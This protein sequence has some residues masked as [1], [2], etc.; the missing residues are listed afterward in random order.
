[1]KRKLKVI[2]IAVYFAVLIALF[3]FICMCF[4]S[5]ACRSDKK[6]SVDINHFELDLENVP[7]GTA[8][9]D[10]LAKGSWEEIG[11]WDN[12]FNKQ[13]LNLDDNCEIVQYDEDGYKSLMFKLYIVLEECEISTEKAHGHMCFGGHG[14]V[15]FE[16]LPY[17]K[18][19]YCDKDGNILGITEK[20][21]VM[22]AYLRLVQYEFDADG[23]ELSYKRIT[24]RP[25]F[26]I[27]LLMLIML[28]LGVFILIRMPSSK[29][30]EYIQSGEV[31]NESG[32]QD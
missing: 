15:I 11:L 1:M 20:K 26:Q 7:E 21:K 16:K 6:N 9:A 2:F 12:G 19:A 13:S 29:N 31:D 3:G 24:K 14:Q 10:I 5:C 8:F 4:V 17:V 18:V 22:P 28:I 25:F 27:W 30:T 23:G 32:K